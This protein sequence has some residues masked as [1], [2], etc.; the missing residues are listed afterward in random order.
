MFD[1]QNG[2]DL[3]A[4]VLLEAG[5]AVNTANAKGFV[6]LMHAC[7]NGHDLCARVLLEAG[8]DPNK[9]VPDGRTALMAACAFGHEQVA[10]VLLEAGASLQSK[11]IKGYTALTFAAHH[12]RV[13]CA[14]VL[15]EAGAD[16]TDTSLERV[17][18]SAP[19]CDLLSV[20]GA[21]VVRALYLLRRWRDAYRL[22]VCVVFWMGRT[23]ERLCAPG[24]CGRKRDRDAYEADMLQC[25]T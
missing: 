14:E 17:R 4:R 21:R 7:Q 6:A 5:A 23:A 2:H 24:G 11:Q 18:Q 20:Q 16:V 10:R 19:W 15:I 12:D 3:C 9:A 1:A 13:L 25:T 22:R 8:A